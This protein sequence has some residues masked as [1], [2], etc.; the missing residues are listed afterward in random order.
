MTIENE[1]D[2]VLIEFLIVLTRI[3]KI[4]EPLIK[5]ATEEELEKGIKL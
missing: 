4:V 5:K 2:Q 3:L 1:R